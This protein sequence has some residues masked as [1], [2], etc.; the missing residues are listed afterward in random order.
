MEKGKRLNF[1]SL[2]KNTL[3]WRAGTHFS[4]LRFHEG[5][6]NRVPSTPG[7]L[8]LPCSW[9]TVFPTPIPPPGPQKACRMT[10]IRGVGVVR[11]LNLPPLANC[12]LR[13]TRHTRLA[14]AVA[15]ARARALR[16]P[17]PLL[18]IPFHVLLWRRHRFL[19]CAGCGGS[20][21]GLGG[22]RG[23]ADLGWASAPRAPRT[24]PR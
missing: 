13:G 11:A 1:E 23:L 17:R 19:T 16:G 21:A 12:A 5:Y 15:A 14:Q 18:D 20:A 24:A 2:G 6:Q 9:V 3:R 8:S 7:R 22:P 10:D 4:A